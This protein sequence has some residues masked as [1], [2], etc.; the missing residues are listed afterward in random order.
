MALI[1]LVLAPVYAVCTMFWFVHDELTMTH[2]VAMAQTQ[3]FGMPVMM[4]IGPLIMSSFIYVL[5]RTARLA[6]TGDIDQTVRQVQG[7]KGFLPG[8]L[9]FVPTVSFFYFFYRAGH[10]EGMGFPYTAQLVA[11]N[12]KILA[13]WL[14][15]A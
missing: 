9:C 7:L 11:M 10:P 8:V 14:S 13:R 5:L 15:T 12:V 1:P 4:L 2:P 6:E 3:T